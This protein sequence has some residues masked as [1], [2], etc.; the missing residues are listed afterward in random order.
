MI[1]EEL[2][3]SVLK[4]AKLQK[5]PFLTVDVFE[6]IEEAETLKEASDSLRKLFLGGDLARKKID[7]VRYVYI[8]S[9]IAPPDFEKC[10][11][12]SGKKSSAPAQTCDEK[13]QETGAEKAA[14][15]EQRK[16]AKKAVT[17]I[18]Q[19]M[20][21]QIKNAGLGDLLPKEEA[22]ESATDAS[23]EFSP[24]PKETNTQNIK[25]QEMPEEFTL[26]LQTPGGLKIT[27]TSGRVNA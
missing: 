11:P 8:V 24:D 23:I 20:R 26:M 17:S 3:E 16:P 22:T 19:I 7:N 4:W 25:P 1:C 12:D 14:S 9:D 13:Q 6:N 27:I 21:K 5:E 2:R 15:N 18:T 10:L